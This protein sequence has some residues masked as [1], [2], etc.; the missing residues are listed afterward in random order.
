MALL[1]HGQMTNSI[2]YSDGILC[3]IHEDLVRILDV[4]GASETEDVI[5]MVKLMAEVPEYRPEIDKVGYILRYEKGILL[6]RLN[7]EIT[8]QQN[9]GNP[10]LVVIDVRRDFVSTPQSPSRI[11]K[12]LRRPLPRQPTNVMTDGSYLVCA[13]NTNLSSWMLK[14][15]D[16]SKKEDEASIIALHTF[17]P[18][19]EEC[20]FK[21]LDGWVYAID[22]N[23]ITPYR[24]ED[25]KKQLFYNCCRFPIDNFSPAQKPEDWLGPESHKP[26]P[27]R[28][29]AVK[30]PRGSGEFDWQRVCVDLVKD[31][32]TGELFVVESRKT[33][34]LPESDRPYRLITF[35]KP[36]DE[37][38]T[39]GQR[40]S[41]IVKIMDVPSSSAH[42]AHQPSRYSLRLEDVRK[43]I[44]PSQ[45]IMDVTFENIGHKSVLH[46]Y[47]SSTDRGVWRFPPKSAP[48]ELRDL[49]TKDGNVIAAAD[50]RSLIV[51]IL[52]SISNEST[53][54]GTQL[55]LVNFDS[56]INFP[57]F[58]HMALD[59]LSDKVSDGK[60]LTVT[61]RPEDLRKLQV[62]MLYL[63]EEASKSN[64]TTREVKALV[65][66]P[67]FSTEPAKHRSEDKGFRFYPAKPTAG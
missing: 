23:E 54:T 17:L 55:I 11:R 64:T 60:D 5:D 34:D 4:H 37:G 67:G 13:V 58:K 40:I 52:D 65:A 45:S 50:E 29:Q 24:A 12:I 66:Q 16:L 21:L 2:S 15:Y 32:G 8:N 42:P 18:R 61:S 46:L 14:C 39:W 57:G 59:D 38:N 7:T 25:R 53:S 51:F 3:Y 6:M 28:L 36:E 19:G 41:D 48:H 27:A 26:L 31:E 20:R 22:A 30:V 49:L 63:N 44:Q 43:C 9:D 56:G 10:I 47:A 35:P 1:A 33:T 62:K